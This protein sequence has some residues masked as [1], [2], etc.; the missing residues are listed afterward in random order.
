MMRMGR[1]RARAE[2][3]VLLRRLRARARRTSKDD[4]DGEVEFG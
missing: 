2:P 4:S 1:I 3:L